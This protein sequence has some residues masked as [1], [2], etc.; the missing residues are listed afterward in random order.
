LIA[1]QEAPSTVTKLT[2]TTKNPEQ[3][4]SSLTSSTTLLSQ[5][6]TT[7]SFLQSPSLGKDFFKTKL[8]MSMHTTTSSHLSSTL[9]W[10]TN[11]SKISRTLSSTARSIEGMIPR[12]SSSQASTTNILELGLHIQA[13]AISSATMKLGSTKRT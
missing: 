2:L 8:R 13:A 9:P 3:I 1:P 10:A 4:Y 6:I 12:I 7:T 5:L 11:P